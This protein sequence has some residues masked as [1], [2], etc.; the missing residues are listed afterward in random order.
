L[1]M[2]LWLLQGLCF[3]KAAHFVVE[4]AITLFF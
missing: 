4:I 2:R 3:F 1:N